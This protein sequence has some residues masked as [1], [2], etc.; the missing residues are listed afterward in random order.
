MIF[1]FEDGPECTSE[2]Y[3]TW[4]PELLTWEVKILTQG[5]ILICAQ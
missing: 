5:V 4:G 3:L 2:F 1:K